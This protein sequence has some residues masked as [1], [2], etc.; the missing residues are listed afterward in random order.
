MAERSRHNLQRPPL[1]KSRTGIETSR[2]LDGAL[3]KERGC[4]TIGPNTVPYGGGK[5]R[6]KTETRIILVGKTGSGKSCT[7][8]TLLGKHAF[9]SESGSQS[10]TKKC[11]YS[12]CKYEGRNVVVIDTPGLFD[13]DM[14]EEEAKNEI[15]KCIALASPG[16]HAIL[17]VIPANVRYT[18]E[19]HETIDRYLELF[20]PKVIDYILPV[21]TK[22]DQFQ[23]DLTTTNMFLKKI[24][25]KLKSLLDK[26][27]N[28]HVFVN[29]R[30]GNMDNERQKLFTAIERIVEHYN[31]KCFTNKQFVIVEKE[32]NRIET[33]Q[34][35][36]YTDIQADSV[37]KGSDVLPPSPTPSNTVPRG[38]DE[39]A[40]SSGESRE[41]MES[42]TSIGESGERMESATSSGKSRE[43]M[44]SATSSGKSRER[45]ETE[46]SDRASTRQSITDDSG[47]LGRLS[48][49]FSDF[50]N[51]FFELLRG[52]KT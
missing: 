8:N 38:D 6:Y 51:S 22:S 27:A 21:F 12:S 15:V 49:L 35:P 47:F 26:N 45:I 5:R 50:F 24:D 14:S 9:T 19:C 32:L 41:R 39:S 52:K 48:Q 36:Q 10:V 33:E 30:S 3:S 40:T 16:P 7:G 28:R 13:T 11:E 31:E 4:L 46:T 29:N 1:I 34:Q 25:P 37:L 20:G 42:A 23:N 18:N 43:R 2:T 17:V 44:E